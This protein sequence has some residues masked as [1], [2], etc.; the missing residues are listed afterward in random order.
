MIDEWTKKSAR[1]DCTDS[2]DTHTN[3]HTHIPCI[4]IK[5]LTQTDF[6]IRSLETTTT[7]LRCSVDYIDPSIHT[8]CIQLLTLIFKMPTS[9]EGALDFVASNC[10]NWK[11]LSFML[12]CILYFSFTKIHCTVCLS[13]TEKQNAASVQRCKCVK[14][15]ERMHEIMY[16]MRVR[17]H[18]HTLNTVIKRVLWLFIVCVY[19]VL[20]NAHRNEIKKCVSS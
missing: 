18:T 4:F 15:T 3:K 10:S 6:L 2:T 5:G 9:F 11:W 12:S 14:S 20:N 8:L 16:K 19:A 7:A 17:E 1:C 13:R